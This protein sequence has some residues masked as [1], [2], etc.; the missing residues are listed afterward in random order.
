MKKSVLKNS[1]KFTGKHSRQS[2]FFNK[3]ADLRPATL[4]KKRLWR[5]CFPVDFTKFLRT[6]FTE[7][8]SGQLLLNFMHEFFLT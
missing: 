3:V 4:F 2:L 5:G 7:N 6:L 1:V 8:T